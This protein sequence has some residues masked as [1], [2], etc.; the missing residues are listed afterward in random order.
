MGIIVASKFGLISV[1]DHVLEPPDLWTKAMGKTKWGDRIPQVVRLADGTERWLIDGQLR[2]HGFFVPAGALSKDRNVEPQSWSQIG[3]AAYDPQARLKAM[4]ADGVDASVLYP[5][6]SGPSGE[7]LGAIRDAE[8]Q[9]ECV[10]TYNDWLINVWAAA[11]PRFIPQAVIPVASIGAAVAE[12]KRAVG[13]GHKGII[14]PAAPAQVHPASPHLYLK[15]WDPL[16]AAIQDLGV[17]V[18]F[19]A[20]SAPSALFDISPTFDTDTARAFDNI[21]Q[22]AGSAAIMNGFVLSGIL[23]RHPKLQAVFAGSA[24]DYVPFGLEAM[25]HQWNRQRMSVNDNMEERPS[26]VFRRQCFVTTWKEKVGLRNRRYIG[27]DRILWQSEF[28]K[29][30]STYPESSIMIDNNF[31]DVPKDDREKI[32]CRNAAKLYNISL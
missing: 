6:V 30:T 19:H 28:P 4:D 22:P 32:L 12:A 16:W 1:D 5:T 27:A 23:Y 2:F 13:R 8:L 11:S 31:Q 26:E 3:Q 17:P 15:D 29:A 24:I 21:R 7:F 10:R 20:G 14:M 18:C 25:D 9:I